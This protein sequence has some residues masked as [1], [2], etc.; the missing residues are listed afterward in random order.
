MVLA[1][2][3]DLNDLGAQTLVHFHHDTSPLVLELQIAGRVARRFG[4]FDGR[5]GVA[6]GLPADALFWEPETETRS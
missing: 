3:F 2:R 6:V 1:G 4:L 5:T